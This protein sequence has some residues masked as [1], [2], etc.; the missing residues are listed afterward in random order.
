[1]LDAISQSSIRGMPCDAQA[2]SNTSWSFATRVMSDSDP[3]LMAISAAALR[4]P[5]Y[6]DGQKLSSTSWAV[7][8][9]TLRDEPCLEAISPQ[10]IRAISLENMLTIGVMMSHAGGAVYGVMLS[11][12]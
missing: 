6:F 9:M 8:A 2:V 12:W 5:C 1:M 7:A 4:T 11:V 10:A 3:L